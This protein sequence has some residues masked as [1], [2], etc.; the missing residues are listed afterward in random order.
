MKRECSSISKL[1]DKYFDQEV[2]P[3]ERS[4]VEGHLPDCSACQMALDSMQN[5]R[6]LIKSPVVEAA[7]K[8]N[9]PWVWEKIERGIQREEKRGLWD[10]LKSWLDITPFLKRK[11]LIPAGAAAVLLILITAPFLYEKI[12]S[13]PVLSVV[14]YVESETYNVMIYESE[15]E[16]VTVIWLFNG[17]EEEVSTS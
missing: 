11:I 6:L 13:Y 2:T 14:E 4:L 15:D 12:T 8:E 5:L 17:S 10:F 9:F 16:K 7:E 3:E 1:L